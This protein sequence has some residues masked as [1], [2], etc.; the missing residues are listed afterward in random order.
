MQHFI[1]SDE[2][3]PLAILSNALTSVPP[4]VARAAIE[5]HTQPGDV[6]LDP[7]CVGVGIIQAA[8]DL[9]RKIIA[10]SFNPIAIL[11]I[12][13]TLW[14]ID[15]RAALTHLADV[16]KGPQRLRD[17]VL[18]LYRTRCP[19]CTKE[20]SALEFHWDRE[21]RALI[22]KRVRCKTCGDNDGMIDE[23]DQTQAA[24]FEPRGLSFWLLHDR[25]IDR[26]HEDADRVDEALEAYT[27][28]VLA[29][30]GDILLKFEGLSDADRSALRPALVATL[31][32]CTA[33][34]STEE[35]SRRISG[36]KPPPQFVEKNIWIELEHIC[37]TLSLSVYPSL[38]QRATSIESLI[39]APNA[40]AFLIAEPAR[41]LAK[42]LPPKSISLMLSHPPP[43]RPG[44]WS[45]STVWSAWL[46]GKPKIEA[47]LPLLARHRTSWDWQWRAISSTL[48]ALEPALK[49]NALNIFSF[50]NDEAVMESVALASAGAN[51]VLDH[52]V[53]DPHDGTRATWH[54]RQDDILS[55]GR[56]LESLAIDIRSIVHEA[57]ARIL[58]DRAEPTDRLVLQAGIQAALGQSDV[59][60]IIA[61]LPEGDQSPLAFM[62]DVV[63]STLT[64]NDSPVIAIDEHVRW[65]EEDARSG[66]SF[67]F[68]WAFSSE[69]KPLADRVEAAVID[70][71]RSQTEWHSDELLREVYRRFPDHLTPDRALVAT[72]IGSYV[73]EI[74]P[75]R[76]RL[77]S[78]DTLEAR[79]AE[80]KIARQSLETIGQR[81][82]FEMKAVKGDDRRM[83]WLNGREIVYSFLINAQAEID[84]LLHAES[85]VL[86]L[87]GGR[88]TL[89]QHKLKRDPRVR[90]SDWKILKF[91][92]LRHLVDDEAVSL[93]MLT[94][95][96]GLEPPIEQAGTQI[97]LL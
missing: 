15:P 72:C 94:L 87:P 62:R 13:A 90:D 20:A 45:L 83:V 32:A 1:P 14:P 9:D 24:R 31:D 78:E 21:L 27:P 54:G 60:A 8:L 89:L 6:I 57:A 52:V 18:D 79:E 30:I 75:G 65:L 74:E 16:R 22:D 85:G 48:H 5:E 64:A 84:P 29:A 63:Q 68:R 55:Y 95:A 49:E 4:S 26:A 58:R 67:S 96:F 56:D 97:K 28:R 51:Q 66:T 88:A 91:S 37:H 10:A 33:L 40:G 34:H 38:I 3:P 17:H 50:A 7:F 42:H 36:L 2:I 11:A 61:R 81:L 77:R 19:I 93:N 80:V 43:P 59:L 25:V 71:L 12:E 70:L 69:T 39:S 53:C 76:V 86:V 35:T 82:G 92:S 46:W 41:E 44:F 47:M 23:D 73:E